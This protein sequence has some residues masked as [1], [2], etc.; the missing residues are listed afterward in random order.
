LFLDKTHPLPHI[1]KNAI[2]GTFSFD[3]VMLG[4]GY[5]WG[6]LATNKPE[7]GEANKIMTLNEKIMLKA[8]SHEASLSYLEYSPSFKY[9]F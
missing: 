1:E 8:F 6:K 2:F 5:D 7:L 4:S 3:L 9:N